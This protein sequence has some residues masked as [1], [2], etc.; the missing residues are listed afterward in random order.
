MEVSEECKTA[1]IA[2]H[3][4]I[5][6]GQACTGK[7]TLINNNRSDLSRMGKNVAMS[8]TTD[9]ASCLLF[10]G[11]TIHSWAFFCTAYIVQAS[12]W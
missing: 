9:I 5:A 1:A 7:T 8:V 2:E 12:L 10:C 11:Q 3:N 4:M 6:L